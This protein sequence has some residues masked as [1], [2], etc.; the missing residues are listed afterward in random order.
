[1]RREIFPKYK[2]KHN[3]GMN[4]KK[5]AVAA[6]VVV[7]LAVIVGIWLGMTAARSG[8]AK[9]QANSD[10]NRMI[11]VM[12][13]N[14]KLSQTM[15]M[16]QNLYVDEVNRDTLVEVLMPELMAQLDPHSVYIPP[17]EM[18]GLNE[19]LDGEFDGIG[20]EFNMA[21]DT[22]VV[23]NVVSNGP[24]YKAGIMAGD[25]IVMIEQDTIAGRN[26]PQDDVVK[27]LRGKRGSTVKVMV[28]RNGVE[29]LI[30]FEIVRDK[31]PIYSID[32][33]F[34]LT[35]E[36]GFI[37]LSSFS[38]S[39]HAELVKAVDKLKRKGMKRLIFDL[40]E[41]SGG[42]LDQAIL[43]ANEFLPQGDMIVYTEDRYG[44]RD[45]QFSDGRG[46]YDRLPL[47]VLI[48]EYSASSSEILAG[49]MQ[50]NDRAAI[51]GR[52]SF[53]KGLVQSQI[54]FADGSAIRL[55]VARYYTPAG[56]SI[57]KPYELGDEHYEEDIYNRYVNNEF[58]SADSIHFDDS[59]KF[60]T[61]AGRTVYGGGG[62]MPD[63]FV[64]MDTTDVTDYYMDV[65]GPSILYRYT[66]EYNDLHRA[67]VNDI[68]SV[69]KL[70]AFLAED[71]R[72][73]EKFVAYAA[74]QGVEAD[75]DEIET[76]R[77]LLMAQ[78]RA[79][80]GRN[81]PLGDAGFYANIYPVD[82]IMLKAVEVADSDA[83]I[84]K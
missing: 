18:S 34:M 14:D 42:F 10:I 81:T 38:R 49:A 40:R 37:K 33:S 59:L 6:P 22:V 73:L 3:Q 31:I 75:W 53:G 27:K 8:A 4:K 55:T 13:G 67:R 19:E 68:D 12:M 83:A 26:F 84:A 66:L 52:R 60:S 78:L 51:V 35:P 46:R 5:L 77:E 24:S 23:L 32:A 20:V 21:T 29:E 61:K 41:N 62:I 7:A 9:A 47:V 57:Q 72:L 79:Y 16:I 36:V 39:S 74:K 30:P 76:S 65:V 1:M 43:I 70:E 17:Q 58:F 45:E 2:T 63:Y 28:R 48:D 64:P 71:D 15:A 44:N 54:P 82:E 50:D 11:S 69:E 25:R 56:R 80:I